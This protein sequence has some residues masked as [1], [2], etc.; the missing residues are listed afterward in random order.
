MN[1]LGFEDPVNVGE[2]LRILGTLKIGWIPWV[3]RIP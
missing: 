2:F 1:S 3:L